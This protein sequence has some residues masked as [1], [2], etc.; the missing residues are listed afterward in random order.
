M[1]TTI[2]PFGPEAAKY[3]QDSSK[4]PY[5]MF[6]V[7]PDTLDKDDC[8]EIRAPK[9]DS[10]FD[11]Q[12]DCIGSFYTS[13]KTFLGLVPD[14][15]KEIVD[16]VLTVDVPFCT[17]EAVVHAVVMLNDIAAGAQELNTSSELGIYFFSKHY[18][19]EVLKSRLKEAIYKGPLTFETWEIA[20]YEKDQEVIDNHVLSFRDYCNNPDKPEKID[21]LNMSSLSGGYYFMNTPAYLRCVEKYSKIHFREPFLAHLAKHSAFRESSIFGVASRFLQELTAYSRAT[22]KETT[23]DVEFWKHVGKSTAERGGPS[24][25]EFFSM[26]DASCTVS[27]VADYYRPYATAYEMRKRE[28]EEVQEAKRRKTDTTEQK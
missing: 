27:D 12:T 26:L 21:L 16:R 22:F 3:F 2:K 1:T 7:N 20:F 15:S 8:L 10:Y 13:H 23:R 4:I 24:I 11:D 28:V 19:C 6:H 5:I 9:Y 25:H 17:M 14:A 18:N